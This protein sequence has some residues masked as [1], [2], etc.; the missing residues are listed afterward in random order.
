MDRKLSDCRRIG[1]W[2]ENAFCARGRGVGFYVLDVE[3]MIGRYVEARPPSA[4][5]F[6]RYERFSDPDL[7]PDIEVYPTPHCDKR[8]LDYGFE[9]SQFGVRHFGDCG[10]IG[11]RVCSGETIKIGE[12]AAVH[13]FNV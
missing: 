10:L 4:L 8:P 12:F 2:S 3:V 5:V 7:F 13:V 1:N 6:E 11:D 9:L